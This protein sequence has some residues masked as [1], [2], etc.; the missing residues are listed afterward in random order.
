MIEKTYDFSVLDDKKVEKLI[1]DDVAMIN[2]MVFPK[3]SGLPEHNS[4]SNVYILVVRGTLSLTLDTQELQ[5]YPK[6]KIVNIP[7]GIRMNV[8]NQDDDV[9]ELFVIKAPSPRMY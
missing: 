4:N 2:H 9:L 7:N 1:D 5:K 8:S 6:G 3:G